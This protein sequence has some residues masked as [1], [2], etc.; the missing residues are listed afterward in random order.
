[1]FR[2][3]AIG[4]CL[5][6]TLVVMIPLVTSTAHNLRSQFAATSHRR[7][8]SRAW[9]RRH[10]AMM[11]RRQAMLVRRRAILTARRNGLA[12]S[13]PKM[14]GNHATLSTAVAPITPVV[15]NNSVLP[16]DWSAINS[17]NGASSFRITPASG[18]EANATLSMVAPTTGPQP[19]GREA[20]N[21]VGGASF[22]EL[23][24]T[25]IDRMVSAGG[26]VVNERQREIGGRKVFEVIAQTPSNDG[27]PGQVW[28]FYFA[29]VD[30]RVY[31]LTTRTVGNSEKVASDAEKLISTMSPAQVQAKQK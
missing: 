11:R 5:L 10:R 21:M 30:G 1:M 20:R 3:I 19:F 23:R 14:A 15:N 29:E 8:H 4:L 2:R 27:K 22:S 6:A 17:T 18:P 9:W 12:E 7:R 28:N 25:V 16:G 31:S 13:A 24:R 26:W